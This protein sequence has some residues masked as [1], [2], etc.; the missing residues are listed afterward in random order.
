MKTVVIIQSNYIPWKGYFDLIKKADELVLYDTAQYT[1]GDWRN[2]NKI[3]TQQ[4]LQWLT[5]PVDV[6]FKEKP[7]IQ[8]VTVNQR[9]AN[10]NVKHWKTIQQNYSKAK[11]FKTYK[12]VFEQLYLEELKGVRYLS[13]INYIL[14]KKIN[15]LLGI[16][17]RI[18]WSADYDLRG[19][20]TE[21]LVNL[22]KD[23][24]ATHYLSG[25]AAKNYLD[26]EAFE[27]EKIEVRWMDYSKYPVY[28]Q[29]FNHEFQ[30]GVSIIDLLFNVG[31]EA[32]HH[33]S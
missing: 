18:T 26:V 17:T 27:K 11:H 1:K 14:I 5:I 31:T 19:G 25:P 7:S 13:K 28:T 22:C 3:N 10:W 15:E 21:K 33:F 6:K 4:G 2:R 20:K 32:P 24:E 29:L 23:L 8:E 9:G 12:A 30:H 16:P